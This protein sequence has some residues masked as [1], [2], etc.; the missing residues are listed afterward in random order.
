MLRRH[1]RKLDI[2]GHSFE[3]VLFRIFQKENIGGLDYSK[4]KNL[5]LGLKVGNIESDLVV[6][7]PKEPTA[8]FLI[9]RYATRPNSQYKLWRNLAELFDLWEKVPRTRI[10]NIVGS[11]GW[12]PSYVSLMNDYFDY[13]IEIYKN[14]Q[15]FEMLRKIE[16]GLKAAKTKNQKIS[17]IS[18]I[19]EKEKTRNNPGYYS[20]SLE[21]EKSLKCRYSK[22]RR[23]FH[24]FPKIAKPVETEFLKSVINYLLLFFLREKDSGISIH[25]FR[26]FFSAIMNSGNVEKDIVQLALDF[27]IANEKRTLSLRR[28]EWNPM[29]EQTFKVYTQEWIENLLTMLCNHLNK[30]TKNLFVWARNIREKTIKLIHDLFLEIPRESL[31]KK[32]SDIISIDPLSLIL[33]ILILEYYKNKG[34]GKAYQYSQAALARN[35]GVGRAL[36][37]NVIYGDISH[38]EHP[39]LF[40][41]IANELS[42]QILSVRCNLNDLDG[43]IV[44]CSNRFVNLYPQ[45]RTSIQPIIDLFIMR[46]RRNPELMAFVADF[47]GYPQNPDGVEIAGFMKGVSAKA[48]LAIELIDGSLIYVYSAY[49]ESGSHKHKER[50]AI[51]NVLGEMKRNTGN[52]AATI[53]LSSGPQWLLNN[54][55]QLNMIRAS[56]W[57]YVL[58]GRE[59]LDRTEEVMF[60]IGSSRKIYAK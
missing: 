3:Y 58:H 46:I 14:P 37:K 40:A 1:S 8:V 15:T 16:N 56:G 55:S 43:I 28:I 19:L 25:K 2:E 23:A 47:E 5:H 4:G 39:S 52:I 13:Q 60:N 48:N 49:A 12:V 7:N 6:G 36:V 27:G 26:D 32:I 45:A 34:T 42:D 17:K 21:L 11:D 10:I 22:Q 50:Y 54:Q 30:E 29:F 9:T 44:F 24:N 53:H 20:L 18:K 59:V 33:I 38:K 57:D 35:I 41:K 51:G 31:R